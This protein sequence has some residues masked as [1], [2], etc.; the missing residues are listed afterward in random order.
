MPARSYGGRVESHYRLCLNLARVG[1]DVSVLTT[2][3]DG[4]KVVDVPLREGVAVA[5]GLEVTYKSRVGRGT[6]S[7]RLL[8]RLLPE[9][10]RAQV[11]HLTGTYPFTTVPTMLACRLMRRPLI[12][13]PGDALRGGGRVFARL[14]RRSWSFACRLAAPRATMLHVN[15]ET[16]RAE[17]LRRF[18]NFPAVVVPNAVTVPA[19]VRH[20]ASSDGRLRLGYIGRLHPLEGI[21]NLLEACRTVQDRGIL[22]SLAIAGAG[23]PRYTRSL[24]RKIDALGISSTVEMV[25]DVH[26]NAKRAFFETLDLLVAPANAGSLAAAVA[27][28]LASGVPVIA[29]RHTP[30]SRLEEQGCGRWT[31]NDPKSLADA[32]VQMG[33][34]PLAQMGERG[35]QWMAAEFTWDRAARDTCNAY[36][37]ML[38][39]VPIVAEN[40]SVGAI[41]AVRESSTQL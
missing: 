26:G 3:A 24:R 27:Q 21:E 17:A 2:N 11:I 14:F 28:S 30:W 12:W 25:G 23:R 15:S 6:L 35:R 5:A 19:I 41:E 18:P 34:I 13:S 10:R 4:R 32:I 33:A 31:D 1:C 38:S 9:V 36:S 40:T 7:P 8:M 22:C 16:E 37:L 29:S 20:R 39:G